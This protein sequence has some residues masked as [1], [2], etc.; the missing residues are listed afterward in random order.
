MKTKLYYFILF[1][2]AL[3]IV[4]TAVGQINLLYVSGNVASEEDT[5]FV[6]YLTP[7]GYNITLVDDGDFATNYTTADAYADYDAV[8]I[9][10]IVGS[11]DV[12]AF[13]TAGYPIPCVTTEG[14][15][16]RV[17]RWD[18]ITDNAVEFHQIEG[19]EIDE[20]V[21][22]LIIDDTEHYITSIYE[23]GEEV[24]WSTDAD[25]SDIGVTGFTIDVTMSDVVQLARY[26]SAALQS[27]PSLWA[28]PEDAAVSHTAAVIPVRI[29]VFGTHANGL[30]EFA[31]DQYDMIMERSLEWVTDNLNPV[32]DFVDKQGYDLMIMPNPASGAVKLSFTLD[33][34]GKVQINIYDITGKMMETVE[35]GYLNAGRNTLTLDFTDKPSAQYIISVISDNNVMTGKICKN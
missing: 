24:V 35:S 9:S 23:E 14:Y 33:A 31:T 2:S 21:K 34:S 29:V 18:W 22:T 12:I 26:K 13:A 11:G 6:N 15:V 10:E 16:A 5:R 28:I 19:T 4:R 1:F 27:F 30:G 20:D 7:Q 32:K 25:V 8:F 3:L 17:G